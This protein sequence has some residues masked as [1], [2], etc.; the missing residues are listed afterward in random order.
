VLFFEVLIRIELSTYWELAIIYSEIKVDYRANSG[1]F[2]LKGE[3]ICEYLCYLDIWS[4]PLITEKIYLPEG[5][6]TFWG[7]ECT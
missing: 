2:V 6:T 5:H 4:C 7:W 1:I 3:S